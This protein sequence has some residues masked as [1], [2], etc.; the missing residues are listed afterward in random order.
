MTLYEM[1]TLRP[2]FDDANHARL[3][4]RIGHEDPPRPSKLVP[5]IPRDLETVVL[6]ASG[7]TRRTVMPR[8]RRWRTICGAF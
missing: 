3:I 2:A 7:T 1:L 4:K 8:P 5:H 6:K